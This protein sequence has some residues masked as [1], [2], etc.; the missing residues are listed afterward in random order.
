MPSLTLNETIREERYPNE[1]FVELTDG[2]THYRVT[3]PENGP[4]VVLVHGLTS[5]YYIWEG[6]FRVL[7]DAG[8]RVLHYD[9]YGRG[10]SDRPSVDYDGSLFVRQLDDLLAAT[11]ISPPVH[12]VGLSMG[13]AIS[14][15]Y[16]ERHPDRVGRLCVMAPGGLRDRKPLAL[17]LLTASGMGELLFWLFARRTLINR[18]IPHMTYRQDRVEELRAEY[19]KQFRY[20]GYVSALLSTLRLG[21]LFGLS[22]SFRRAGDGREVLAVWGEED[23][24][25]PPERSRRLKRAIPHLQLQL[26]PEAGHTVNFDRPETVNTRLVEFLG[27]D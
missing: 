24:V 21:P 8:F 14:A 26:V 23:R 19:R 2:V 10:L 9:L 1:T 15:L 6:Q 13:G 5:P 22:E 11:G 12:L 20:D 25:V 7:A 27:G 4:S 17:K 3:G 18:S 16:A